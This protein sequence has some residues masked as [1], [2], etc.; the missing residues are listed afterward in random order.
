MAACESRRTD[1][2]LDDGKLGVHEGAVENTWQG[3]DTEMCG[4]Q[5][6]FSIP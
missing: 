2:A 3:I 6:V 4:V 5:E 1:G